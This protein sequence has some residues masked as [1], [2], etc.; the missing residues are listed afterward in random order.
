MLDITHTH[1]TH[2]SKLTYLPLCRQACVKIKAFVHLG[3]GTTKSES[4]QIPFMWSAAAPLSFQILYLH[5]ITAIRT[6]SLSYYK[7]LEEMLFWTNSTLW[8]SFSPAMMRNKTRFRNENKLLK[9]TDSWT[10][11]ATTVCNEQHWQLNSESKLYLTVAW[12]T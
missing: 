12:M 8:L 2:F 11:G 4:N 10:I 9:C 6:R 7:L 1:Y 5:W 3:D